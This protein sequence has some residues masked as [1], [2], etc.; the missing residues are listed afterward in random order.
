MARLKARSH[1]GDVYAA[2]RELQCDVTEV[3]DFSA[4]INP[5][6]PSPRVW[7]AITGARHVLSHYPDP[8]CWALR[9]A[10]ATQ[11]QCE[12]AQIVVGNG[13]M[14]L[15]YALPH[16]LKIDH[17]L[18]V[19]PTFSEYAAS[20]VRHGGHVSQVCADRNEQYALPVER[21]CGLLHRQKNGPRAI[22]G[23]MFCNPNSPTG[24]ACGAEA[25]LEL[26]RMAQRRGVWLIVDETFADYC[27]ERSILSLAA[28]LSRVVVL[29]SLT[30]FYGL[31][32]LRVGYAVA[33]A[34]VARTLRGALP[35]WSVNAMGQ[36]A[37]LA[38]LQ[39]TA[40]ARKSLQY[41]ITERT[42][43]AGLL[44]E[45][46]GCRVFPAHA[47]YIF[48]ELPRGWQAR[49]MTERLRRDGLL[50]RDCSRVPGA[51]ARS[52]RIAV[53]QRRDNDR[54]LLALSRCLRERRS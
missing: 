35:P 48:M 13:S 10:L 24:Q 46:P 11:W 49:Q 20:M 16:A 52:I 40:H 39:D 36:V 17:L 12:S 32:G 31:P 7:R 54:L 30:K 21:L 15:I 6:G 2:S 41:V 45:L 9:Q 8:D 44:A 26:A 29:R 18:V 14:E 28:S 50:I 42:R 33:R 22:D 3:L 5:L 34:S 23:V 47:N 51:N 27:P 4:S 43:L 19:Q 37:A 38:A 53:R 25:V 1:G